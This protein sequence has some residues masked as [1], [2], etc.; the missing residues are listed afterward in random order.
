[1][2][3]ILLAIAA[4]TAMMSAANAE[5][6]DWLK[7][8][9]AVQTIKSKY[10]TGLVLTKME[11]KDTNRIGLDV[12]AFDYRL[13]FTKTEDAPPILWAVGS[14]YGRGEAQAK[15]DGYKSVSFDQFTRARSGLRVR[16]GV[17][18]GP[19]RQN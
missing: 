3:A 6:T 9:E 12:G 5:T 17:W 7:G 4:L 14:E 13:T 15:R 16:C 1:M 18:H 10:R 11:C 19:K 2:K 8:R